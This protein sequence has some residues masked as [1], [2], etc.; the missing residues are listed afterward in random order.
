MA[1]FICWGKVWHITYLYQI[2]EQLGLRVRRAF[3]LLR[4]CAGHTKIHEMGGW[5]QECGG[6]RT[7]KNTVVQGSYLSP[8]YHHEDHQQ[9]QTLLDTTKGLLHIHS[10]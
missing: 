3:R 1:W 5:V 4:I 6:C 9:A 10:Y 8:K 2:H 7:P